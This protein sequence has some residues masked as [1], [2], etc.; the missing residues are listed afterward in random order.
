MSYRSDGKMTGLVAAVGLVLCVLVEVHGLR[1]AAD[2]A[3]FSPAVQALLKSQC[4]K[5]HGPNKPKAGLDLS[6]PPGLSR[7]G[8]SGAVVVGGK[9]DRSLLWQRVAAGEMPPTGALS[10]AEKLVLR[11]WILEGAAGLE[12]SGAVHWA[13]MPLV[14]PAEPAVRATERVRNALDRFVQA[15]LERKGLLPGLGPDADQR[16]LV[17]RV[18]LDVTG[19]P[20][21]PVDVETFL[22]D[23][24][25]GAYERMVDRYLASPGFGERWGKHW[26]DAAG[27]ADSNGYFSADTDRPLAY[28]YRDYVIQSLNAGKPFDR[29]LREQLAG[30]EFSQF[31]PG[32][33][34][35]SEAIELLIATHFLR[36]GQDGT[37]IGVQEPEAFEIDRRAALEAAVQVTASSLLGLTAH[38]ARCH[39]H[40]FEPITQHEY[41]G[42]QAVLFPAFNPQDWMNPKDR[43]AYAYLPGEKETWEQNEQRIKNE[44]ARIRTELNDWLAKHREPSELLFEEKFEDDGWRTRWSNTAPGD[45]KPGGTVSLTSASPNAAQ[46]VDGALRV[47]V[48]PAEAWLATA[49]AIDWTPEKTGDWV[50]ATFD[51]VDNKVGANSAERI[52]YTIAAHDFDDSGTTAGGNILVDG[53]PMTS[54]QL[55]PDYPG[56]DSKPNGLI[57][58]QGY[59]PGRNYGVRVTNLGNEK[60]RLEHV[61]DGLQEGKSHEVTA[62]DL[63]NGGFAFFYSSNRSYIVDNVRIE[64]S[65]ATPSTSVDVAALRKEI[66]AQRKTSDEQ[67]KK[68]EDQRTKE[69]GRAIAWVTDKTTKPPTV[70]LL[71]RGLYHL[72]GPSVEPGTLAMLTD[73][74][75]EY[76]THALPSDSTTTGR[77]LGFANWLLR[78]EGRPAALVA[79]VHVNR[80]WCEYFGRGIV[81]TTDNLGQSGSPPTHPELINELAAGFIQSGW[82]QKSVHRQILLSTTYRQS[83]APR[84]QALEVDSDNRLYWRFPVRRLQAELIR[85]AMLA[86]SGQLDATLFGPYVATRQTSVGEVVV[87][88]QDAGARRRSIYLQQ[89]RSQTLSM[90]KVFD[91]PAIATVCTTRPSSTVPLQSLSLLNSDFAVVTAEAFAKRLR[92]ETDGTDAALIQRAWLLAVARAPTAT[93]QQ[94]S[95]EFLAGQ[96]AQYTGEQAGEWGLA[97]FCQMLLASNSFLYLE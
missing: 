74:G 25:P 22:A 39:D 38:C 12:A 23:A 30:D 53:N 11:T 32:T 84:P 8:E 48:G 90:L 4:M 67:R 26:L 31:R 78:S 59:V 13:F 81:A 86:I 57:G 21:T 10:D 5:C 6:S 75:H 19:L 43:I 63:P 33:A 82:N 92:T 50:Q 64:R 52:G 77:R 69:P 29:F 7:G 70:P 46:V 96:R 76:Q 58:L 49:M 36:N 73:A 9:L 37:D 89:R 88:P 83:S 17:R 15:R 54:T 85:D 27:Y 68:L 20:P 47:I 28:R 61:V 87:N 55:Y 16:V 66:E 95:A 44:L 35:T 1:A 3:E 71:T 60:Y 2:A 45:D 18:S 94:V 97:D 91:A 41:Y 93:E 80:I 24:A 14:R 72:R 34:T 56:S 51:L 62:A 40:K 79:R 65:L 42:L